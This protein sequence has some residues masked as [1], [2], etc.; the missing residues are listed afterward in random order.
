MTTSIEALTSLFSAQQKNYLTIGR[1]SVSERK[2]DLKRLNKAILSRRDRI[3]EALHLD[4]G[5]PYVQ[6]ITDDIRPVKDEITMAL[7]HLDQWASIKSVPISLS[8]LGIKASI[9]PEPKGVVLVLAPFNF[10]FNLALGPMV[11]ALAA[12]N[13]CLVKPSEFTPHTAE[14][15]REIID[16]LFESN[17]IACVQGDGDFAATLTALPFHHI[18]FTGGI[19]T[20]KKVMK[21][22][23]EN[24]CSVTLEL[25]GKSPAVVHE[26][27][28]LDN[29]AG[30]IIWGK[31]LNS[32]QVCIAPDYVLIHESKAEEFIQ[33][34]NKK[35]VHNYP[36]PIESKSLSNIVNTHHFN[37][38]VGLLDDAK[39][40]GA[41]LESGGV[42]ELE[43]LRFSP[44]ILS[45]V[46]YEMD[47]MHE[48]IFGPILPVVTWQNEADLLEKLAIND[49]ALA[50]YLFSS[51]K[52][53]IKRIMS[54]TRAGT[55]GINDCVVQFVYPN[56]PFGG[57]NASGIGK[58]HG[59]AGFDEFSNQRSVIRQQTK[60]NLTAL[61]SPPY[62]L[63]TKKIVQFVLKWF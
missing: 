27:A 54:N 44:T 5:K 57:V 7:K 58:A 12:G 38:L 52:T 42:Y 10:P 63:K 25:G 6:S 62:T 2:N 17:H 36:K 32:G 41:L 15:I 3:A 43:R 51:N 35:I 14:I 50:F 28:D 37:R 26:D 34:M 40:K 19:S 49:R 9:K 8:L 11:S 1:R 20:G 55:T 30:R 23:A 22:A 16:E 47:V 46:N 61:I 13:C 45:G 39:S 29:A 31:F 24:L 59:K 18:F 56:L 33:L 60:W 4:L 53:W 48:E 21:A